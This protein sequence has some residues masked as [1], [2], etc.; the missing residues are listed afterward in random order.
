MNMVVMA[1]S[2]LLLLLFIPGVF[3]AMIRRASVALGP[4]NEEVTIPAM[5]LDLVGTLRLPDSGE[6]PPG[7]TPGVVLVHGSGP[8]SRDSK[9]SSQHQ[10]IWGFEIPVFA[11]IADAL[12]D[13]GFAVL[14]Y[15]KRTCGAFNG[16]SNNSYPFPNVT[17]LTIDDFIDDAAAAIE[18]LQGHPSVR[19]DRVAVVG[20]SQAGQFLPILLEANP[21][22]MSGVMLSAPYRSYDAIAGYQVLFEIEL[23][24]KFGVNI[25]DTLATPAATAYVEMM[26]AY[27]AIRA[28]SDEPHG[29]ISAAFFKSWFDINP[30]SLAAASKIKQPLLVL[31]GSED[32]TVPPNEAEYWAKYLSLVGATFNATI[33]PCVTHA[34]NCLNESDPTLITLENIGTEVDPMVIAALIDFLEMNTPLPELNSTSSPSSLPPDKSAAELPVASLF[35]LFLMNFLLFFSFKMSW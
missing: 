9:M 7:Q 15:D 21:I 28:G 16:C 14:T 10:L 5:D 29:G 23:F 35:S 31:H 12:Q 26:L 11:Q 3:A 32:W 19:S 25:S 34:L 2:L 20:H 24:E 33:I 8:Q 13:A 4:R 30:R 6:V 1:K 22:L 27:E 17:S 18:F